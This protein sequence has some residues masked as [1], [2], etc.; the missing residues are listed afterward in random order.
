[1]VLWLSPVPLGE[2]RK[3]DDPEQDGWRWMET[4]QCDEAWQELARN[5][6]GK[7]IGIGGEIE[8]FIHTPPIKR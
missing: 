1:M 4:R 2:I 6:E 8:N 3:W 7:I 5:H